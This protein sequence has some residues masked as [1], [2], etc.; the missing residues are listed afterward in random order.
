MCFHGPLNCGRIL[1]SILCNVLITV[2]LQLIVEYMPK[3]LWVVLVRWRPWN[4]S[5]LS[6]CWRGWSLFLPGGSSTLWI[7]AP[8]RI[9]G[10]D[11]MESWRCKQRCS[12]MGKILW[13]PF[14]SPNLKACKVRL[15]LN[16]SW[17]WSY[18]HSCALQGCLLYPVFVAQHCMST[19]SSS[20]VSRSSL[21]KSWPSEISLLWWHALT[22][23]MV[24]LKHRGCNGPRDPHIFL[25]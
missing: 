11:C 5:Y 15:H 6:W 21:P 10:C 7:L 23:S 22:M 4:P 16:C 2:Q 13:S 12:T 14:W 18:V 25:M 24:A 17:T 20:T 3:M 19:Y 9:Q 8:R 1:D